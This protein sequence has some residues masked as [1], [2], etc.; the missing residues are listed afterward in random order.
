MT[1]CND[2]HHCCSITTCQWE[3]GGRLCTKRCESK[4][5]S[6][7]RII[8]KGSNSFFDATYTIYPQFL[9]GKL[10]RNRMSCE[11]LSVS[12]YRGRKRSCKVK[13]ATPFFTTFRT[14]STPGFSVAEHYGLWKW[15]CLYSKDV[16]LELVHFNDSTP[17]WQ[18]W[19]NIDRQLYPMRSGELGPIGYRCPQ[20]LCTNP[21][22][23][24]LTQTLM[25]QNR[26]E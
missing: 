24:I 4:C 11:T 8:K 6:Y 18:H 9:I 12:F 21:V 14:Q 25:F 2:A 16:A 1:S 7:L 5:C 19:T 20:S 15:T 10:L 17:L 13:G 23:A 26:F 22:Y 3:I